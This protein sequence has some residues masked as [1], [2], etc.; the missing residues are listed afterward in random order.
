MTTLRV[1]I[2]N[3]QSEKVVLAVLKALDLRYQVENGASA[4]AENP[5]P[6]G[7]KWFLDPENMALVEK[8]IADVKA[9]RVTRIEDVKKLWESI[10]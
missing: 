1:E 6:S 8:G 2:K 3:K 5:S 7:D 9:G 4:T 10:L